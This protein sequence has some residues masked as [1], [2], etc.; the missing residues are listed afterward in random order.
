MHEKNLKRNRK[1][2]KNHNIE[3][4][5][6]LKSKKKSFSLTPEQNHFVVLVLVRQNMS[7]KLLILNF[8][9]S[10]TLDLFRWMSLSYWNNHFAAEPNSLLVTAQKKSAL[11]DEK[12]K[13]QSA[14]QH[15]TNAWGVRKHFPPQCVCLCIYVCRQQS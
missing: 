5:I 11:E 10:C 6:S 8:L 15:I 13:V 12:K 14:T 4:Q 3:K 7:T 2:N 1:F 9:C